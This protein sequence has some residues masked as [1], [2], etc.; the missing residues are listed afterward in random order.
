M[1]DRATA[2]LEKEPVLN[3]RFASV[4]TGVG[5]YKSSSLA[6]QAVGAEM[7]RDTVKVSAACQELKCCKILARLQLLQGENRCTGKE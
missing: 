6:P 3:S 5:S 1:G 7:S 2:E 4:F